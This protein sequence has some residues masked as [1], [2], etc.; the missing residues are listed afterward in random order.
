MR[1][2]RDDFVLKLAAQ[3][4]EHLQTDVADVA[5]SHEDEVHINP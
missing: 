3:I 5:V 2:H 1:H 4:D